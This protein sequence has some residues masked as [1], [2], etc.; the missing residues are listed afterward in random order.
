MQVADSRGHAPSLALSRQM[1]P[2]RRFAL[3][4]ALS[5]SMRSTPFF[6]VVNPSGLPLLFFFRQDFVAA[7][8][9]F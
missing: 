6:Y 2:S 8:L 7:R 3:P 5:F 9:L 1:I 4:L